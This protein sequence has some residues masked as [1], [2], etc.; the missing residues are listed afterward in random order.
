MWKMIQLHPWM[1]QVD[2]DGVTPL[3][4]EEKN[5]T[6]DNSILQVAPV[7]IH[8]QNSVL[9]VVWVAFVLGYYPVEGIMLI[10]PG[11]D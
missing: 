8:L 3:P 7:S 10:L 5:T 9:P 1:V 4:A 6:V 11:M 2:D